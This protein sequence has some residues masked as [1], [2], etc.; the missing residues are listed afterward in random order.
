VNK[1]NLGSDFL[2]D[3]DVDFVN[4]QDIYEPSYERRACNFTETLAGIESDRI[5]QKER[6]LT[7][8]SSVGARLGMTSVIMTNFLA[9]TRL[10]FSEKLVRCNT[11]D[12]LADAIANATMKNRPVILVAHSLGTQIAYR[13]LTKSIYGSE[14][15]VTRFVALGSQLGA[16]DIVETLS[17][18]TLRTTPYPLP[19]GILSLVNIRGKFD[20][21]APLLLA[22][23][24]KVDPTRPLVDREIETK[25][26]EP[27][28]IVGY[29][30]HPQTARAIIF[31]WC[32]AFAVAQDAPPSCL[33]ARDIR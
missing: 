30:K 5:I 16:P 6:F 3:T 26:D 2:A 31:A 1:L 19:D 25:P 33:A 8:L 7:W 28:S 32:R 4:Y 20:F 21:V 22:T 15:K 13:V 11:D 14:V 12:R 29:L 27:H 9:D 24:F 23:N 17:M 18:Q 10:Y